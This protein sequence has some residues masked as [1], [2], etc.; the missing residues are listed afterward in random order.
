MLTI[1]R[2]VISALPAD[3]LSATSDPDLSPLL[4]VD[5]PVIRPDDDLQ[6]DCPIFLLDLLSS[7]FRSTSCVLCTSPCF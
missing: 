2:S 3:V 1:Q 5:L 4:T 7:L 6:S